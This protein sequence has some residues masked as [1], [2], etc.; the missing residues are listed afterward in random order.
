MLKTVADN[1]LAWAVLEAVIVRGV[2]GDGL[3]HSGGPELGVYLVKPPSSA[4]MQAALMC[5]VHVEV[6]STCAEA[7][8]VDSFAFFALYCRSKGE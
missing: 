3:S 1:D 5:S 2:F 4:A 6:G 8:D 7:A